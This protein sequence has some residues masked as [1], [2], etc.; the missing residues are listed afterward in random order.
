V[1]AEEK[2]GRRPPYGEG[3]ETAPPGVPSFLR[4]LKGVTLLG[5][6]IPGLRLSVMGLGVRI[7]LLGGVLVGEE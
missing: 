1:R 4:V 3:E 6:L 5:V 2:R 7:L